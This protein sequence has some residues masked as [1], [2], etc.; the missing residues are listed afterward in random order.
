MFLQWFLDL[1]EYFILTK[2]NCVYDYSRRIE[3]KRETREVIAMPT[4]IFDFVNWTRIGISYIELALA[5]YMIMKP[6][7]DIKILEILMKKKWYKKILAI[8]RKK[9]ELS[10]FEQKNI[11]LGWNY[12][13]V[14]IYYS[15]LC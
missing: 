4:H 8:I 10:F 3:L 2:K 13:Y 5:P 6:E 11:K 12:Y 15:C 7:N 1:C 9:I 14:N